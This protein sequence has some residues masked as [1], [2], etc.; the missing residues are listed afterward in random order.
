MDC[1]VGDHIRLK[2]HPLQTGTVGRTNLLGTRDG[3]CVCWCAGP[4]FSQPIKKGYFGPE[5]DLI[6][7]Y[8]P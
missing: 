5:L 6:E 3:V 7:T 8:T 2:T 1:C 4:V